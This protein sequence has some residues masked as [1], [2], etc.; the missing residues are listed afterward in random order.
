MGGVISVAQR[1]LSPGKLLRNCSIF[2]E[3]GLPS[4]RVCFCSL[5]PTLLVL[6]SP[7]GQVSD[8]RTPDTDC[9]SAGRGPGWRG[10]PRQGRASCGPGRAPPMLKATP[11]HTE[12]SLG[13]WWP[14]K[15][16]KEAQQ[17][18]PGQRAAALAPRWPHHGPFEGY[19]SKH[20]EVKS[21][22]SFSTA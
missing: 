9:N 20:L 17:S 19:H 1:W 22:D 4:C 13:L 3:A 7:M 8:H 18:P 16:V 11:I 15:P 10:Q 12:L 21:W 2:Q 14:V 5:G 6:T